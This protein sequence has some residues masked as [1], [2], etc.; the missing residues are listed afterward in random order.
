[1]A[2]S[3]TFKE[4]IAE[5]LAPAGP[6]VI[7]RM[8]GGAGASAGGVTFA[9]LNDDAVYFKIDDTTR[10]AYAAEAMGPFTYTS[11]S[12][13]HALSSYWKCPPRLL[14]EPDEFADWARAAIA[15]ARRTAV[16]NPAKP[17]PKPAKSKSK[18]SKRAAD[19]RKA[20]HAQ[21]A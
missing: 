4:F 20:G 2:V 5:L 9:I 10:T 16:A 19:R 12:G 13:E 14:D 17:K 7:T 6:V 1:M 11:K 21:K 15:V 18:S 8:F 3:A